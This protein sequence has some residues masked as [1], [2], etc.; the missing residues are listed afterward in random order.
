MVGCGLKGVFLPSGGGCSLFGGL[1]LFVGSPRLVHLPVH[2]LI[3]VIVV[4]LGCGFGLGRQRL[5]FRWLSQSRGGLGLVQIVQ[6]LLCWIP[7]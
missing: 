6:I 3:R 2:I 4:R 5:T 1:T 7:F